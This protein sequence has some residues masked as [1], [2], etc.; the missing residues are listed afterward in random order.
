MFIKLISVFYRF[1][2][3]QFLVDPFS[4]CGLVNSG[5]HLNLLNQTWRVQ[6]GNGRF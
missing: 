1:G 2:R 5:A 6:L 3:L 4:Q